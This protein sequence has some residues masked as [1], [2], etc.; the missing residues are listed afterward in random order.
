MKKEVDDM[1]IAIP[2][3][4]GQVGTILARMFHNDGHEVIVFGRQSPKPAPWRVEQWNLTGV[5]RMVRQP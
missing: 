3:G 2:S 5:S 4:T 1:K